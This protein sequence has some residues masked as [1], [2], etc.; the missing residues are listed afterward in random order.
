MKR[1]A[2]LLIILFLP[3]ISALNIDFSCP[4]NVTNNQEFECAI[5]TTSLSGIYDLKIDITQNDK[6]ISKIY[7]TAWK[8]TNYYIIGFISDETPRSV[9]LI[10]NGS[11][12]DC[13]G[14]IKLRK[15]DKVEY[16][17]NFTI[18]ISATANAII[19]E[20][21]KQPTQE[22]IISE[23]ATINNSSTIAL[24]PN[25]LTANAISTAPSQAQTPKSPSENIINL[26]PSL[27]EE[28]IY[29]SK[30]ERIKKYSIYGFCL[31]LIFIIILLI[32]KTW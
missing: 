9:R 21:P 13:S 25:Y 1:G 22:P 4:Q 11:S 3:I 19:P 6:R 26:N 30:S 23:I 10:L 17:A 20:P 12:G 2:I 5:T 31:F 18:F 16:S 32:I 7:N 15:S 8:S 24:T 14:V 29:E 27:K 28:V